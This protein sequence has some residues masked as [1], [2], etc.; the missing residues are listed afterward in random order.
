MSDVTM[1]GLGAMGS[2]IA[3]ALLNAGHSVT[4][5]NRTRWKVEPFVASGADSPEELAEAVKASPIILVCI[6]SYLST[7]Q[8]L[9]EN[10][11]FPYLSGRTLIQLST[12][13]PREARDSEGW[14]SATGAGYL[15]GAIM[16]YPDG[17]GA[18]D[19]QILFAGPQDVYE[20]CKP[21][22]DCLGGDLRYLG[23]NI[24]AAATLN[25][26]LL[27]H[28]LCV[29]LGA[30]HGVQICRSEDVGVEVLSSMFPK[31]DWARHLTQIINAGAYDK[32]GATIEVWSEAL[33][34]IEEQAQDRGIN[35]EIPGFVS[36]L[37]K[38]AIASG[39][40]GK[41]I[42]ALIKVLEAERYDS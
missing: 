7:R 16:P 40:G 6:D 9:E 23:V 8:L 22:L 4:V 13:S 20:R 14:V 42:A 26:A 3:R 37:L 34:A 19:A 25:M 35:A 41:D 39:L 29:Y 27:T 30:L 36:G 31:N 10:L 28:E 17:I 38:R 21:I 2:A 11:V 33:L 1:L 24:G 12:G 15:V 32:P 18:K 5:W